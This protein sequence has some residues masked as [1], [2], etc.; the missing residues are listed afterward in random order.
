MYCHHA[1]LIR[2][3]TIYK[4]TISSHKSVKYSF[5]YLYM[6]EYNGFGFD[7]H[8]GFTDM[9]YTINYYI[10]NKNILSRVFKYFVFRFYF[11]NWL[12]S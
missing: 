11:N 1:S 9:D 7:K 12:D 4:F 2:I 6:E 8:K 10:T 3:H 5:Y